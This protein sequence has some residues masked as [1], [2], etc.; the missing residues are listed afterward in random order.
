MN[1]SDCIER[2]DQMVDRELSSSEMVEV[3]SHLE[4]CPPCM[5]RY[6]LEEGVKRLVR[7]CCETDRAPDALRAKLL[8]ILY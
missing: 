7:R 2:L 1:C 3:Q 4:S 5:D 6:H 8:E